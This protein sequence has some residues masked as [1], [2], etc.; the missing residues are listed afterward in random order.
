MHELCLACFLTLFILNSHCQ[1]IIIELTSLSSTLLLARLLIYAD[2]TRD[3]AH[4]PLSLFRCFPQDSNFILQPAAERLRMK[5]AVCGE[6]RRKR[7]FN[8]FLLQDVTRRRNVADLELVLGRVFPGGGRVD[9]DLQTS[10][11]GSMDRS[12][13]ASLPF[14]P[15]CVSPERPHYPPP[16]RCRRSKWY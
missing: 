5:H 16:P 13:M 14:L 1:E 3:I 10:T 15:S 8:C 6:P 4:L 7:C 2:R 12:G 9:G 11:I